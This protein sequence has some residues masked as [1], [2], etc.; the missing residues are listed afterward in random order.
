VISDQATVEAMSDDKES[1]TEPSPSLLREFYR[2]MAPDLL[3]LQYNQYR[4]H[5]N[6]LMAF[7]TD[8][9]PVDTKL[10]Y[11]MMDTTQQTN[12]YI[13]RLA[14]AFAARPPP[15]GRSVATAS[16]RDIDDS[17]D[18]SIHESDDD[19]KRYSRNT[20][21]QSYHYYHDQ[22]KEAVNNSYEYNDN[23]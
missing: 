20:C 19:S 18:Q 8:N 21:G 3:K 10:M 17:S 7:K 4:I 11:Q 14:L 9:I 5:T 1:S 16:H 6:I 2:D 13:G 15:K 23:Q 22:N 12:E